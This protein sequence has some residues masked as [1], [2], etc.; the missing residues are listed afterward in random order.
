MRPRVEQKGWKQFLQLCRSVKT[1]KQ[2][3][4]FFDLLLTYDEKKA[5][6]NRIHIIRELL[7]NEKTQRTIAEEFCVSIAKITRGSNCLKSISKEL[8]D[9]LVKECKDD[10]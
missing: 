8:R 4:K 1:G 5:I 9:F 6:A 2:L 3:N 7:R 10:K